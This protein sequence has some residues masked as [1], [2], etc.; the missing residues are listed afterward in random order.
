MDTLRT[1]TSSLYE[2]ISRVF[3]KVW[4]LEKG[5][6]VPV[7]ELVPE[8]VLLDTGL[9]SMG[10]AIFVS[11]LDDELGFDPFSLSQD[12]FYPQTF[13]EFVEFYERHDPRA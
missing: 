2:E 1:H 13:A 8:T 3:V 11:T 4:G 10:F 9:D 5:A 6:E 12:A 7:P